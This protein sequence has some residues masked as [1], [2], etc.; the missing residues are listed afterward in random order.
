VNSRPDRILVVDDNE[1]NRDMLSRR[2]IKQ[3]YT[4]KTAPGGSEALE[5]IEK[6]DTDLVL[7]DIMMPEMDGFEVLARIRETRSSSVLPVIMATAKDEGKDVVR[8]LDMG[9]NDY[10]TKPFDY[11]VVKARVA[12][13]V[14]LRRTHEELKSSH[15]RMANDLAAAARIQGSLLPRSE[16]DVAEF[17]FAWRYRPCDELAGD[18]LNIQKLDNGQVLFYLIDVSGHG[19]PAALLSVSVVHSL[20]PAPNP[21]S[22]IWKPG[23]GSDYE[24]E[25]PGQ[26]ARRLNGLYPVTEN[27][28][29]Y[30]TM[31][32]GLLDT[33]ARNV[34]LVIAGHPQPAV[35]HPDGSADLI[36]VTNPP[37]GMLDEVEYTETVFD[38]SRGDRIL[39]YSDGLTEMLNTEEEMFGDDRLVETL[40]K[41][42]TIPL[43]EWL[44]GVT[45]S[46]LVWSGREAYD[47][48]LSLLSIEAC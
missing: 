36:G 19:V 34:R 44:D 20:H 42:R 41:T 2:L 32:Y 1:M 18:A 23:T 48:D 21:S 22:L 14:Q 12:T 38:R 6:D 10:V 7:L 39:F 47:D 3:G 25:P 31:I 13:Q 17:T 30:F 27:G 4:V 15:A 45:D 16:P 46:V 24:L 5:M 37:I 29:L 28:E 8:A 9:A 35:V 40:A 26:V 33:G 43:G 11:P